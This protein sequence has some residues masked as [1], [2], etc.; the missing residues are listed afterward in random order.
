M[1]N[2]HMKSCST[3]LAIKEMQIKTTMRYHSTPIRMAKTKN[4]V[5]IKFGED[6]EKLDTLLIR[7]ENGKNLQ[8]Y[9]AVSLKIKPANTI[10]SRNG[11]LG[12]LSQRS[13]DLSSHKTLYPNIYS[14]FILIGKKWK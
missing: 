11:T 8:K 1:V 5:T 9:L 10:R 6:A 7:M 2:K 12:Y 4:N 13:D 14:G 3:S